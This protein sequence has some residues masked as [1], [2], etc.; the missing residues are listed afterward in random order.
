MKNIKKIDQN[1][2]NNMN[3]INEI[4]NNTQQWNHNLN[5]SKNQTSIESI[6]KISNNNRI[7]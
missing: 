5:C 4:Q 3:I 6:I 7:H 2:T 1:E